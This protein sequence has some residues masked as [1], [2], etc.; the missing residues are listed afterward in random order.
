MSARREIMRKSGSPAHAGIDLDAYMIL[1]RYLGEADQEHFM[2]ILLNTRRKVI[3]TEL[4]YKGNANSI[5]IRVSEVLRPAVRHGA[6]ALIAAHNHP[7]GD[8]TPS[9]EDCDT[10]EKLLAGAKLLQ[11]DLLDHIIV[12]ATDYVSMKERRLG[13]W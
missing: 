9:P 13:G 5:P 3:K 2:V 12:G 11:I 1:K 7:S 6:L 8:A 4:I 10:N